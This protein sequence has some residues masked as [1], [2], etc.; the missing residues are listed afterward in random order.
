MNST[1]RR[2]EF[3]RV[4]GI[5]TVHKPVGVTTHDLV[6]IFKKI[7]PNQK[8]GHTGTLDPLAEGIVL[9]LLGKSTRLS[10]ELSKKNKTYEF[11]IA[12]GIESPTL[13]LE[14][15]ISFCAEDPKLDEATVKEKLELFPSMYTQTVP[16][17]S[18]IKVNGNKLYKLARISK[19]C[20]IVRKNSFETLRIFDKNEGYR[21]INLPSRT[22]QIFNKEFLS[23]GQTNLRKLVNSLTFSEKILDDETIDQLNEREKQEFYNQI[24]YLRNHAEKKLESLK[25]ALLNLKL[26]IDRQVYT[27]HLRAEVS[28]GFY[29]RKFAEDFA[30]SIQPGYKSITFSIK[31]LNII[32]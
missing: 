30:E 4:F 20:V 24:T 32:F 26:D 8:I 31:R 16:L 5:L 1:I 19:N 2:D 22:V 17:F 29:V 15:R 18:S 25:T 27:T 9:L 23:F 13:D 28:S 14:G 3:G 7:F 21:E 10:S 6:N 12:F 11:G